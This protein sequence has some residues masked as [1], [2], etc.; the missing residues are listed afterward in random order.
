MDWR[1][2]VFAIAI[3]LIYIPLVFMAVNT[4]FPATP[5]NQC[6]LSYKPYP[7]GA[8]PTPAEID[9]QNAEMRQCDTDYRATQQMYD[10]WKFIVIMIVNIVAAFVMLLKMD[11]SVIYGLFFGVVITAFASTIRY[12]ESRS[13]PGFCLLVFLFALI[14]FFVNSRKNEV[15]KRK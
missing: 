5:E 14:I 9:A 11:M 8:E 3:C 13:I 1:R 6:Y 7:A 15:S 10:G 2:I 4:F 12:M